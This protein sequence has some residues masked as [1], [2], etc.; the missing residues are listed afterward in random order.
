MH[1]IPPL[2]L[3]FLGPACDVHYSRTI[4]PH[5]SRSFLDYARVPSHIKRFV[6]GKNTSAQL[7][8]E[9]FFSG[10]HDAPQLSLELEN[11]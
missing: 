9:L 10:E 5:E 4:K 3:V 1:A 6:N 11:S 2:S 7:F 8:P